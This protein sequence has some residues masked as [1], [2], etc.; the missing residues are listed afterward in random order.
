[1]PDDT[2]PIP[3][4][5]RPGMTIR[6]SFSEPVAPAPQTPPSHDALD[7]TA[8]GLTAQIRL[9]DQAYTLRITRQGKLI[10]TK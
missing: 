9:H 2:S 3:D 1:M 4:G 7:L 5:E 8:G 6:P 10:L